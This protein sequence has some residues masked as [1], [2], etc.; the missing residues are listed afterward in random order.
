MPAGNEYLTS[1]HQIA[2][3][4]AEDA[5]GILDGSM[6]SDMFLDAVLLVS[7]DRMTPACLCRMAHIEDTFSLQIEDLDGLTIYSGVGIWAPTGDEPDYIELP[8]V[9]SGTTPE[10]KPTFRA[11]VSVA[12]FQEFMDGAMGS[13]AVDFDT[14]LPLE[15]SVAIP[16]PKRVETFELYRGGLPDTPAPAVIGPI[17]GDVKLKSGYNIDQVVDFTDEAIIT[18]DITPDTRV[19]TIAATPGAGE[20]IYPCED[21][22]VDD[23]SWVGLPTRGEN[24]LLAQV[25]PDGRGNITIE[26]GDEECYSIVPYPSVGTIQIQGTCEACCTCE[27]YERVALTIADLQQRSVAI[28]ATLTSARDEYYEPGVTHFNAVIAQEYLVEPK[29]QLNGSSGPGAGSDDLPSHAIN[30]ATLTYSVKNNRPDAVRPKSYTMTITSP[31]NVVVRHTMWE[32][33][34]QGGVVTTDASHDA[35]NLV[36][37]G[38]P[39]IGTGKR[40]VFHCSLYEPYSQAVAAG[41]DGSKWKVSMSMVLYDLADC[42]GIITLGDSVTFE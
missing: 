22:A 10:T 40:L 26:G 33:D 34:S 42:G 19:V 38:V 2:Y 11:V 37:D 23:P 27:D 1:N 28:L 15:A 3:P 18:G 9:E 5:E 31:A 17:S 4:F 29:L 7:S 39:A 13:P 41:S 12:R 24:T 20:G 36:G 35:P 30:W 32:Y 21:D 8:I 25:N 16:R 6:P 14:A